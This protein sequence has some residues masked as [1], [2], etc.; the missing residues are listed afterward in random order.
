V[1]FSGWQGVGASQWDYDKRIE[2]PLLIM[3]HGGSFCSAI[4]EPF[5]FSIFM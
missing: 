3:T 5:H 1:A 2:K 4:C